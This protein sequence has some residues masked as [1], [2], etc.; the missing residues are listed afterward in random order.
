M[1]RGTEAFHRWIG[2]DLEL[3]VHAAP[4]ARATQTQGLHGAS[5][6]V[7]IQARAVEGA[8]N[9]ALLEFL[10]NEFQVPR[11]RCILLSGERSREKRVLVQGPPRTHAHEVL[12]AWSQARTSS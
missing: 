12:R 3:R 7:R 2:H 9:A 5:L 8:A 6:K 11:S 1:Q 4:G 10:A